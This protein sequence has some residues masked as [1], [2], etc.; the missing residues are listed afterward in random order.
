MSKNL[1]AKIGFFLAVWV[2]L[3]AA[4]SSKQPPQPPPC[5]V[6]KWGL[7]SPEA[8]F[9]AVIPAG[10]FKPEEL[11][12]EDGAGSLVYQFDEDGVLSVFTLQIQA[13]FGVRYEQTLAPLDVVLIGIAQGKYSLADG[14]QVMLEQV[15]KDELNMKATM[16]GETMMDTNWAKDFVPLFVPPFTTAKYECTQDSLTLTILNQ[17]TASQPLTFVRVPDSE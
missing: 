14:D 16:S 12:F 10:A 11:D 13:R 2:L 9:Y 7:T 15:T 5:I 4:C 8:F 3:L 1:L 6:G 17:P